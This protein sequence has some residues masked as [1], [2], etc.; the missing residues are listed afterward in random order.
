[1][2][3]YFSQTVVHQSIPEGDISPLERLLLSHIFSA[4]PDEEG[5][6]FFSEQGPSDML[7][8]PRGQ[9]E[10]ALAASQAVESGANDFIRSQLANLQADATEVDLDM[11]EPGWPF[12]FQDIVRRSSTLKYVSIEA[13]FTCS[14]MRSDGFGGM[15]MLITAED[16]LSKT[17]GELLQEFEDRASGRSTTSGNHV[18]CQL[19]YPVIRSIIAKRLDEDD[20]SAEAVTDQDIADAIQAAIEQKSFDAMQTEI[21]GQMAARA[22]T[23]ARRRLRAVPDEGKTP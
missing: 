8:L 15:A 4:E 18:L 11:S 1:M 21:E 20:I 10:Q 6:Y 23:I 9:L 5:I 7:W 12:L 3:D 17:T 22:I 14:K 13:A 2:A 19:R 16:V